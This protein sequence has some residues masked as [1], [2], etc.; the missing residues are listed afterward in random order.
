MKPMLPTLTFEVPA[1]DDWLFEVKYDGFRAMLEMADTITLTS[2]NGKDLLPL[3]PEIE[4]Y[5]KNQLD[6][7]KPYLPFTFDGE[8]VFLENPFK[9]N[10]ALIQSRG[11][12][13]SQQR[14]IEKACKSPCR[15][16]I[17]DVLKLKG[18]PVVN[19]SYQIRKKML[20][21]FFKQTGLPLAPDDKDESLIQLIP[22]NNNFH[23]IWENV[24][25][26]DG[27]GVVAK[28]V[29]SRWEEGKRTTMWLKYKNWKYV[30]CFITAY[31][32]SNSYFYAA[33]YK[34]K[35][36]YPI[37]Q[38]IFGLKP[39][40]KQALFQIIKENKTG[41]DIQYIY[42]D[43]AICVEVKYLEIYEG[44]MREPHFDRFRFDLLPKDCTY[45]NF[46]LQQKNLP[47]EVEITHPEKPLWETPPVQKIDYLHFLREISPFILPFLKDRLLTVIRY[48]HG[49][50]GEP[51][52]QK[53]CPEYA[54]DFVGTHEEEGINY[55]VCNELKTLLWLGN[56]L[57][58][59]FHIPFQTISS[60]G[61]SEIVFD[62]DPPSKDAFPL[63][64]KAANLIK[65]VLDHLEL[66]SFIKTSGNKGL[67]VYI[68]LPDNRYSYDDTRL[69]TS[70]VAD[71]L[72]SKDPDSF[73]T[74]R[75]K[76]KR[77][78][79]LYVD[80]IQHAEG[81]TI[82]APYSPRGNSKATVAAPLFWEEVN[83]E[84]SMET[85]QVT[86][87]LNRLKDKG[88]PFQSFF[89]AKEMQKFQPVLDFLKQKK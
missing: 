40:E 73:T 87:I 23:T 65:E 15:L 66:I 45:E 41:E 1:G 69:F 13:R 21:D 32:K 18:K 70:F 71:Y 54:P 51:F 44:Q 14:I 57:A 10:F 24:V 43:P 67:Q 6:H 76:K 62:L 38:F 79:R 47:V 84:L 36:I 12:M 34:D 29:K 7:L 37:G 77:G 63:A 39:D 46:L 86:T 55:I 53:N 48:P 27:E 82:I 68:P 59:E 83:E 89:R 88:D 78:N 60:K 28:Q 72:V 30:S 85:F 4:Q 9:A 52:Y 17:F 74:E 20:I 49:I 33:V 58:F 64:I 35:K 19:S 11:R 42:V 50:F 3:F 56:Q 81:K 25:L 80:Y 16:L 26:Y 5:L 31:E 61:P 22:A 75:M 8:L 2:R